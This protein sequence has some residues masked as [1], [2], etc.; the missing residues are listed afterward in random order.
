LAWLD[1]TAIDGAMDT[2]RGDSKAK[3][4]FTSAI[5]KRTH[6]PTL[7]RVVLHFFNHQTH[8]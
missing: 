1:I 7:W 5:T 8:H 3:L 4:A 6:S 2:H